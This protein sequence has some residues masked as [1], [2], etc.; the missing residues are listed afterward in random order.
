MP[1]ITHNDVIFLIN[2]QRVYWTPGNI[3][4]GD[5]SFPHSVINN[6]NINRIHLVIDVINNNQLEKMIKK[7]FGNQFP[8]DYSR[9]FAQ[10][11]FKIKRK[12]GFLQ[13]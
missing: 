11:K 5:F 12:L 4:Y 3:Y 1:I 8:S 13:Y 7:A 9:K 2:N 6:S 10:L